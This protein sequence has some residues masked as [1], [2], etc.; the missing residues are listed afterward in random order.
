MTNS[1]NAKSNA[2]TPAAQVSAVQPPS[3]PRNW[4]DINVGSLVLV[5]ESLE[6]GWWEAIV[7]GIQDANITVRWRDYPRERGVS[8]RRDQIAL[9]FSGS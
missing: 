5:Q 2:K 9:M 6:D 3:L 8:R 7:T 4:A 1:S